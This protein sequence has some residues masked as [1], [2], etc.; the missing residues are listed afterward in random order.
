MKNHLERSRLFSF[1]NTVYEQ[2]VAN[3][4]GT[5]K[6]EFETGITG[7]FSFEGVQ[8][9]AIRQGTVVVSATQPSKATGVIKFWLK[10]STKELF[11]IKDD[12]SL[13]PVIDVVDMW[14]LAK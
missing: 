2:A 14:N 3:G 13:L 4:F 7:Q 5:T 9:N 8:H 12:N 6:T 11:R 10:S 1:I